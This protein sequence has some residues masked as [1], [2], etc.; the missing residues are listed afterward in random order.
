MKRSCPSSC[1]NDYNK[2]SKTKPVIQ[3][4]NNVRYTATNYFGERQTKQEKEQQNLRN[5]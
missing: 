1:K 2:E 5:S 3:T 4:S